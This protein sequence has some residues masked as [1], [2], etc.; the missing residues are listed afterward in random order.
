[1]ASNPPDP[2]SAEHFKDIPVT[3]KY[4]FQR[5]LG[6]CLLLLGTA[7]ALPT[8]G[9]GA[10]F[11]SADVAP[12]EFGAFVAGLAMACLGMLMFLRGGGVHEAWRIRLNDRRRRTGERAAP[13]NTPTDDS[14]DRAL[15]WNVGFDGRMALITHL[16]LRAQQQQNDARRDPC[17]PAGGAPT[18]SFEQKDDQK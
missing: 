9:S 12:V 17:M 11:L 18:T 5:I 14:I 1:M 13:H 8:E 2:G 3:R 6:A 10:S 15:L 4:L 16:I 7:I